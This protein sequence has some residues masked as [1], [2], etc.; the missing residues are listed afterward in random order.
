MEP[1][2]DLH[3]HTH[4]SD[5]TFSP[6][7][8]VDYAH[9]LGL[10]VIAITDHDCIDGVGPARARAKLYDIE[11]IPGVELTVEMDNIEVHILGYFID[12]KNP[13]FEKKLKE[14]RD[15][16][17]K[18]T[19]TIIEKLKQF[20]IHLDADKVFKLSG[21]GA[22]G[23]L[24]VARV[25]YEEGHVATISDAFRKYIGNKGPCYVKKFK[26]TYQEAIAMLMDNG[27]VPVLAHPHVMGSDEMI[28]KLVQSGLRGIE[29]YH[30]DH[31]V[32]ATMKY[33]EIAKK[34]K[35][36]IT[37]GSDCHGLGKGEI[38][39]GRVRVPAGAVEELR[40]EAEKIKKGQG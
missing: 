35:L 26:M 2:V 6:A 3:V 20:N 8:V 36:I 31:P 39:M 7:E 16:R 27:G 32:A 5:G 19:L 25:L 21:P 9:K 12:N 14:M 29:V 33:E 38:L 1:R 28:P 17:V 11:V 10:S 23:R 34:Y 24:H 4:M 15:V 30:T 18:R 37:G 40:S 22:I 13:A